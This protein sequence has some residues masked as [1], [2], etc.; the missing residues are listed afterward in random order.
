MLLF[1]LLTPM[2]SIEPQKQM[3]QQ[4]TMRILNAN[5]SVREIFSIT[6]FTDILTIV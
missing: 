3:D 1:F 6:G 2:F 5:E 4:G